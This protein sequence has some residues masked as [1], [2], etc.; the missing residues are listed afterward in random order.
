MAF[1]KIYCEKKLDAN[2]F[3]AWLRFDYLD[4]DDENECPYEYFYEEDYEDGYTDELHQEFVDQLQ[5]IYGT[6]DALGINY[7]YDI[8]DGAY[9]N[10][11]D[12]KYKEGYE[13][14]LANFF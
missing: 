13:S 12:P 8:L 1:L 7:C 2:I 3:D 9:K 4:P 5:M 11:A 14:A 6:L 10:E